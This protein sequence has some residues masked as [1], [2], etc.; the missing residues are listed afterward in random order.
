V[1]GVSVPPVSR[2]AKQKPNRMSNA[3]LCCCS[4]QWERTKSPKRPSRVALADK[5]IVRHQEGDER[6]ADGAE[7]GR[8]QQ[9]APHHLDGEIEE[10]QLRDPT[11]MGKTG[12]TSFNIAL[13]KAQRTQGWST[14]ERKGNRRPSPHDMQPLVCGGRQIA[15]PLTTAICRASN[16]PV[17]TPHHPM[18]HG[19][20]VRLQDAAN[21]VIKQER[22]ICSFNLAVRKVRSGR[23]YKYLNMRVRSR[24]SRSM[25]AINNRW[26]QRMPRCLLF[27]NQPR[28]EALPKV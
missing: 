14:M 20:C 24:P 6:E 5:E 3:D 10:R 22:L 18:L 4:E 21:K 7:L 15:R 1:L 11:A 28:N 2:S 26:G 23:P 27:V 12:E 16:S 25:S 8:R 17:Q 19:V 9:S 13:I